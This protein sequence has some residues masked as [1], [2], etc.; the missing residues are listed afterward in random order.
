[1]NA[2]I[3]LTFSALCFIATILGLVTHGYLQRLLF[4]TSRTSFLNPL[5]YLRLFTHVI[6]HSSIE[7][8][9]GNISYILLLGPILEE[10]YG[11]IKILEVIGITAVITGLVNTFFFPGVAISGASGV[12]FAFIL[13]TSFTSF[14]EGEIPISVILVAMLYLGQQVVDGLFVKD[15]IS[16]M[17]HIVGGLVGAFIGYQLNK[18][19]N[20]Y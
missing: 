4:M 11:P 3:T 20:R 19:K 12:V 15:N 16:N 14:R 8:F 2:P 7:H 17:A 6:G 1:M 9:V 5:T 10:K 13:L 18:K